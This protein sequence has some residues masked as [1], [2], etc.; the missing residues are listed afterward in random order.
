MEEAAKS[1]AYL[2]DDRAKL[3]HLIGGG[4]T[5]IGRDASNEIVIR[6]PSAS[7]FHAEIRQEADTFVLRSIGATGTLLNAR[8]LDGP[9]TLS[10]GDSVEIAFVKLRFARSL[11]DGVAHAPPH[12]PTNDEF[13][14]KPT[15]GHGSERVVVEDDNRAG[16]DLRRVQFAVIALVVLAAAWWWARRGT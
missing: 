13:A 4:S 9:H 3:A 7:R 6:D 1:P 2:I 8:P 5:S 15:H 10:E 12:S 11:G 16:K 14:R